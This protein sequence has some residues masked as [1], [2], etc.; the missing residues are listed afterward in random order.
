M[1]GIS[2][3]DSLS[4]E[5]KDHFDHLMAVYA[6]VVSHLDREIG[7]LV[8]GLKGVY[9]KS[10]NFDKPN[11]Y[12]AAD[13]SPINAQLKSPSASASAISRTTSVDRTRLVRPA[14]PEPAPSRNVPFKSSR[15]A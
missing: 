10:Y 15:A 13:V 3:W 2:A 11:E 1:K 7:E 4:E 8:A 9:V 6:A 5:E 14:A 12:S